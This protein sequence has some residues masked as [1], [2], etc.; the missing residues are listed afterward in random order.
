MSRYY[1]YWSKLAQK[2][3][4]LG[5]PTPDFPSKNPAGYFPDQKNDIEYVVNNQFKL[6]YVDSRVKL[7]K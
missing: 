6:K 2:Q 1:A 4:D 3:L 7:L 5:G